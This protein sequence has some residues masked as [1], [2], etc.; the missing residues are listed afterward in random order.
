MDDATGRVLKRCEAILAEYEALD[1]E[2]RAD[3]DRIAPETGFLD[4]VNDIMASVKNDSISM[5]ADEAERWIETAC[6]EMKGKAN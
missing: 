2:A 4:F 6:Q 1:A 3:I 5:P